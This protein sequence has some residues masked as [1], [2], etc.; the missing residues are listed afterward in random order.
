[1]FADCFGS[2]VSYA[3]VGDLVIRK[4]HDLANVGIIVVLRFIRRWDRSP[5]IR[6]QN[7]PI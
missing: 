1:M 3:S 4:M 6:C 7:D 5:P 2:L